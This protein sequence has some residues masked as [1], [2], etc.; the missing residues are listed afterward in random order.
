MM[1]YLWMY[2][3]AYMLGDC[4]VIAVAGFFGVPSPSL[5]LLLVMVVVVVVVII[6]AIQE[7]KKKKK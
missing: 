4:Y 3:N 7:Q 5:M 1:G 6:V 2:I